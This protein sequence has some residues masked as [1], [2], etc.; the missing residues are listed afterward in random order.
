[1][2]SD[3]R[4]GLPVP[5]IDAGPEPDSERAPAGIGDRLLRLED[6]RLL[7]GAGRFVED[8]VLPGEARAVFLRSP[9]AYARLRG[10][11]LEAAQA[12]PGVLA[13]LTGADVAAD[14]LGGVPWEVRPPVSASA[15]TPPDSLPDSLPPL[16]DPSVAA[17]QPLIAGDTVRF[18]GEIVAMVVAESETA[19]RDAAERI[20]ADYD[21]LPASADSAEAAAMPALWPQAPGN[22]GFTVDLGDRASTDAAFTGAAH[23]E[24]IELASNRIFGAPLENR[25]CIG[26]YEADGGPHGP[27]RQRRQAA[28]DAQDSGGAD[29][30]YPAREDRREGAGCRRRLRHQECA[31]SRAVPRRC[32]RPGGS[33]GRSNGSAG[34]TKAC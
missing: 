34:A 16:G 17:P 15:D 22:L 1:M 23:I 14:E 10:L 18:C 11:S 7:R 5:A 4:S 2:D 12:A 13:V 26:V 3:R 21:P 33:A 8:I 6:N 32:G 19:A 29:I 31:L 28:F 9:H 20:E 27:P 24:S 30:P 25:A